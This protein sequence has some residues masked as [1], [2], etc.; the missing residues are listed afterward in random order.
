MGDSGRVAYLN[1]EWVPEVQS[2]VSVFDLGVLYGQMVFEFTRTYNRKPF[3]LAHHIQRLYNSMQVAEIDCGLTMDEMYE[4]TMELLQRNFPTLAEGDDFGIWHNCSPGIM[5]AYQGTLPQAGNP[6]ITMNVW[7]MSLHKPEQWI[8]QLTGMDAVITPQRTVPSKLIDPK[9]K[10]RSRLHYRMAE[11]QAA[12]IKPGSMAIL[13]DDDGHI[14]EGTSCNVLVVRDGTLC[15]PEPRNILRGVTRGAIIDLAQALE[16]PFVETNLDPY[17][18][19]T[20][21]EAFFCS[22]SFAIM[23]IRTVDDHRISEEIPGPVTQRLI[24]AFSDDV[25]IDFIQQARDLFDLPEPA[26]AR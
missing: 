21:D 4:L 12:R 1:G 14:S 23:P 3:R 17:D 26:L 25:G 20:A 8:H 7:P 6:T 16:I 18:V 24:D 5:G 15:S 10:N 22:T 11:V 13:V 2:S 19:Y 9:V